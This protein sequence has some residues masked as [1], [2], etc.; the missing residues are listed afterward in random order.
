MSY[1]FWYWAIGAI[2]V[3][4]NALNWYIKGDFQS[5][6]VAGFLF[7]LFSFYISENRRKERL[8]VK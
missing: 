6:Y 2:L 1:E 4:A 7:G 5:L 8:A 3:C